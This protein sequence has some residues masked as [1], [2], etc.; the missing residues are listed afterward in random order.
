MPISP[1]SSRLLGNRRV[2][3]MGLGC[4][5]LSQAYSPA[6]ADE[7]GT[8]ILHRALDLGYD[9]LDTA[10][11][12]GMGH[13]EALLGKALKGHRNRFFLASKTGI[14]ADGS[15]RRIDC[16]PATIRKAC[17]ES[18]KSLQTD[19]IDLYYLHRHDYDTPIEE[20]VGTLG[21][22]IREGKIGGV[23][24]SEVSA[25]TLRR[26]HAEHP[27]M[28]VQTEYS[29]WT[30][31]PELGVLDACKE[32]GTTF[33]A[34]SPVGRGVL[35]NNMRDP[36]TLAAHD[37]RA[38][39]PRFSAEHWP[40]NLDLINKFNA[41]AKQQEVTSAQL[42][43]AWVLSRGEHIVAIPGTS[44]MDHMEENMARWDWLPSAAVLQ[45]L[46]ELINQQ[47]VS[48]HRYGDAMRTNVDTE[49][50]AAE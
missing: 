42:A 14:F 36:S 40:T 35:A 3:P 2:C 25:A 21:D 33:V 26:A 8:A 10:R 19:H 9:H 4:M 31:N 13:N 38:G 23:G 16:R 48:G 30:R 46:D 50:F 1:I 15:R 24:L 45:Q 34:F 37:F 32:L 39:I 44:R 27:V 5:S 28:A 18:L 41:I 20:S 22:L 6:P 17:E 7:I 49:E 47:T 43:L 29:L 12:Y 11:I